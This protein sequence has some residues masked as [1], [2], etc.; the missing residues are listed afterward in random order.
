MKFTISLIIV[1]E[2][3]Q[4]LHL[5]CLLPFWV[6]LP[7]NAI[8]RVIVIVC[9]I[10]APLTLLAIQYFIIDKKREPA[11]AVI[12]SALAGTVFLIALGFFLREPFV[13]FRDIYD[14][15]GDYNVG[16]TLHPTISYAFDALLVLFF[17][18]L[19]VAVAR[20]EATLANILCYIPYGLWAVLAVAANLLEKPGYIG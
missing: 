20:K 11:A 10:I 5:G 6:D 4:A 18:S 15:H 1:H 9:L 19:R 2:I 3:I 12:V 13:Q 7:F 16:Y 17:A 14:P 8:E